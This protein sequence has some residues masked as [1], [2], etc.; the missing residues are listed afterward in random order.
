MINVLEVSRLYCNQ[1]VV[2]DRSLKVL[3]HGP[4]L[5]FLWSKYGS[6]S[7]RLTFYF[8]SSFQS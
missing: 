5:Q 1:W 7:S 3:D 6:L 2:L 4:D 8:A